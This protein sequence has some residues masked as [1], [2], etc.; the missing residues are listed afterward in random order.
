MVIDGSN[1][2]HIVW[3]GPSGLWYVMSNIAGGVLEQLRKKQSWTEPRQLVKARCHPGDIMLD[4]D[5][6]VVVCY[7]LGDRV[8][9]LPIA[10]GKAELAAGLGAGMPPLGGTS[11]TGEAVPEFDDAKPTAPRDNK[12]QPCPEAQLS[13]ATP[14]GRARVPG[15]RDGHGSGRHGLSCFPA[16]LPDLGDAPHA[17]AGLATGGVCCPWPGISSFDHRDWR[18]SARLLPV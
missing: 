18:A 9:Y 1:R 14:A 11:V 8:Y 6:Q 4:A 13:A 12:A 17:G 2:L 7:S 16:R 3:Y 10:G 5:G 15:N